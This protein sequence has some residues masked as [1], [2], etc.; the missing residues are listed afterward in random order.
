MLRNNMKYISILSL[1]AMLALSVESGARPN[2][3][4]GAKP[5]NGNKGGL[6]KTAAG[7]DPAEASIDLDI[8]NIRAKMM[9]GGDMWWDI[10]TAEARYEVPKGTKKNS[11]FA[12]SVWIG[13]FDAQKQLKVAAQTYRQDGND[14]WPGPLNATS[15]SASIDAATCSDW[16]RFWK[17]DRSLVNKF[18]EIARNGGSVTGSEFQAIMEWPAIGNGEG[19]KSNGNPKA[20]GTSGGILVMGDQEYAP[21][22]DVDGNGVYNPEN[23]EPDYPDILGDQFIWWVFNDRGNVKQQSNTESI[24]MEVQAS[25]FAFATKDYLND[26]TFYKYTLI[27]RTTNTLDSAYIATWTDADLGYYKDDY[28][29]CDTARGLGILYNGNPTDGQGEVNSYADKVPMVGIDFFEGPVRM[30]KVPGTNRDTSIQLAMTNFT[31]YNN[32]FDARIGNPSNG[33]QIYNYMTG[34]L[35]NGQRFAYDFVAAGTSA[36]GLGQGPAT[37][38]LFPGDPAVPGEWSECTCKNAV[39]D[40]RFIHSA[41]PFQLTPGAKNEITIGAVWVADVGGCPN[42]SFK[43]IRVADDVA[44][45]LFDNDFKTIEGPEAPRM[46]VREMDNKLVFYLVNDAFSNNYKEQYGYR[47]DSAKYRVPVPKARNANSS[48]SLYRFEGYRVFQLKSPEVQPA[49]I[50]DEDGK[51]N[52]EVAIE[53]FQSDIRNGITQMVNWDKNIDI[54]NCDTCYTPIIKIN[55]KDSGI[56]HSFEVTSDAFATGQNKNLV[57]YKTYYFAAI[58]YAH[59]NFTNFRPSSA[60][61]TQDIVY[62]ESTHGPGGS[63]IPV[64]A[65]MPNPANG[66]MGT[67]LNADYG[68][69]V[70]IKKISGVGNGGN[71]L[72]LDEQSEMEALEARQSLMPV[73][74]QGQ[75]PIDIQVV[76]PLMVK[77][78]DWEL[79]IVNQID[80]S[81]KPPVYTDAARGVLPD[82]AGWKLMNKTDGT[83]I[84]GERNIALLNEQILEKYG[85]SINIKQEV[86]PGDDQVD[87]NGYITSGVSFTD[88]ALAW[89]GGVGD[90]E[91]RSYLNWIR[92]GNN[93]DTF[94]LCDF[95]DVKLDTV[96]QFYEALMANNSFT[97]GSW[98]PYALGASEDKSGCGF[99]SILQGSRTNLYGLQSVDVV[100]TSDRSKWTRCVVLEMNDDEVLAEGKTPKFNLRSHKSWTGDVDGSG[101]PVYG[102]LSGDLSDTGMS[103]FPGYAVNQETGER[104]NIVFSEDSWLASDAGR[105]MIWNPS[106]RIVDF[107]GNPIFGGRHYVY[108]LNS[109]YDRDSAFIVGYRD[110]ST[111]IKRN[112]FKNIMWTGMPV[113]NPGFKYLSLKDG[114][115][116]TE[117]RLRIRVT[118]PYAKYIAPGTTEVNNGFPVYQFSTKDLASTAITDAGNPYGSD[119]QALLDRISVVPNPYYAYAGYE[120]NRLDTRVKIINL[121][122]RATISIYSLDGSLIRRIDKDSKNVSFVDWDIKNAKGLPIA[123][124]MYLIHINAEGVGETILRWFGAMRPIDITTY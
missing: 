118:R 102:S 75:G 101:N 22:I 11:L 17:V 14:Y 33:V 45:G 23:A 54:V 117:T 59:N 25:A 119:K 10:G 9:T 58:A 109:R 122:Q 12:G 108:V 38:F 8:N 55:G 90:Q 110:P 84:Y 28:I 77:P 63:P 78:A 68:S 42:T 103:W 21:F 86:R 40:R 56:A 91:N 36:T 60:E 31:Y 57:N 83:V 39:D 121:P 124:G 13:G 79:Y 26:A 27:N 47:L 62:L 97:R 116:P 74:E 93:D 115:I 123:S 16:D 43:K 98:A 1:T 4:T 37:D 7:C 69:G 49:Q 44:Q 113:I 105:D 20:T 73:Y 64:I 2:V 99:G 82:S 112:A 100:F 80:P 61:T 88:P 96:G 114:I 18:R 104:L 30:S 95:N 71:N 15:G 48:D 34:S 70:I 52:T 65:A 46:V 107:D 29:G 111:L 3:T 89:L 92:S 94:S 53:V 72:Q 41:G 50:L 120:I 106:S 6:L 35:R 5:A 19:P 66:N 76:D 67:V 51:V 87:R 32:N 81:K 85:M 24:G